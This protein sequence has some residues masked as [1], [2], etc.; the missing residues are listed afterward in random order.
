MG[1]PNCQNPY[2]QEVIDRYAEGN[3]IV[4][5]VDLS[6]NTLMWKGNV[7][8]VLAPTEDESRANFADGVEKMSGRNP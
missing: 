8:A 5:F 7:N 1:A 3:V 2:A 4:D 6:K